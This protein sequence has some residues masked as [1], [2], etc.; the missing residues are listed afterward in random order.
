MQREHVLLHPLLNLL[1]G[2]QNHDCPA[3]NIVADEFDKRV[4]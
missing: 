1:L 2:I 3:K 4:Y